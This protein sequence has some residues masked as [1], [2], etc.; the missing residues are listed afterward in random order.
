MAFF[1][2]ISKK[3]SQVSQNTAQISKLNSE[4]N[5]AQKKV[6]DLYGIIGKTNVD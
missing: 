1:D 5:A 4:I 3:I 2:D 6:K